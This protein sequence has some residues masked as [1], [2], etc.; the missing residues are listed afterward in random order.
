MAVDLGSGA[1]E[2]AGNS[3]YAGVALEARA[4]LK[5]L[6]PLFRGRLVLSLDELGVLHS[7]LRCLGLVV[8]VDWVGLYGHRVRGALMSSGFGDL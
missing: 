3:R 4:G 8:R 1:W 7:G 5:T 2:A 6:S